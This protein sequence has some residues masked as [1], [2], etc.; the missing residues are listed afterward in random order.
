MTFSGFLLDCAA[1]SVREPSAC[2]RRS[3]SWKPAARRT[4]SRSAAPSSWSLVPSLNPTIESR[5]TSQWMRDSAFGSSPPHPVERTNCHRSTAASPASCGRHSTRYLSCPGGSAPRKNSR[6]SCSRVTTPSTDSTRKLTFLT[7][8]RRR[9]VLWSSRGASS[10]MISSPTIR[11]SC[12]AKFSG[13]CGSTGPTSK[14][15][16]D[17]QGSSHSHSPGSTIFSA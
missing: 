4:Q 15:K 8:G 10:V 16:H 14:S 3:R 1:C 9:P 6:S 2:L 12:D 5:S 7:P 11:G 13:S 17:G